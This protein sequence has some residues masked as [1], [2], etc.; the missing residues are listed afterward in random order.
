MKKTF[1]FILIGL[2]SCQTEKKPDELS[3]EDT[4]GYSEWMVYEGRIPLNE[5]SHLCIE[6]S[7]LPGL[8]TGEGSYRLEEFVETENT[9][10]RAS[11]FNG[12]YSTFYGNLPAEMIIQLIN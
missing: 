3:L 2:F 6:V 11:Y 7:I 8:P 10:V 4:S 12:K 5:N 9:Y 1:Y